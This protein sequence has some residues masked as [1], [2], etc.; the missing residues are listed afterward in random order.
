MSKVVH[1]EIPA[2]DPSRAQQFYSSV[3][4]W[5]FEG[6][7]GDDGGYWLTSAG[8]DD[9]TGIGGALIERGDLH[10]A[11]VVIIG[12]ESVDDALK[13]AEDNGAEVL[14]PSQPIPGVGYA[15]YLRDPEGNIIGVF[16]PD[17]SAG[18]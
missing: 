13:S 6:W 12:V 15:G 3:F 16:H 14:S 10:R 7:D 5:T 8:S 18:S 17:E 9:E 4:G 2:E 11:P 1:F